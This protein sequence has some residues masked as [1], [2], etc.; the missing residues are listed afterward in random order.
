MEMSQLRAFLAFMLRRKAKL[1]EMALCRGELV[2][3]GAKT[4]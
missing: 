2:A 3:A 4:T 1:Q